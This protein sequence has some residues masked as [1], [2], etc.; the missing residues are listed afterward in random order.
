[1]HQRR[2]RG[3]RKQKIG[4][5]VLLIAAV[6]GI[7]LAG[8]TAARY[9][10]SLDSGSAVVQPDSFYFSSDLLAEDGPQYTIDPQLE[11]F[12]IKLFNGADDKRVNAADISYTVTVTNGSADPAGGTIKGGTQD[13]ATLTI[14]PDTSKAE[15]TVTVT[16]SSPYSKTLTGT[17]VRKTD[18]LY[19]VE[20]GEGDRAAVLNITV[21]DAAQT[22]TVTLPAG[23]IPDATDDRVTKKTE[24]SY[25]FTPAGAGAY[26]LVLLKTDPGTQLTEKQVTVNFS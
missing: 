20:D 24:N 23:V 26:S 14:T 15:V 1:M 16:S 4:L 25:Q 11:S 19:T 18:A 17:F 12:E 21:T 9:V 7:S 3:R 8:V 2:T 10:L 13:S 5:F 22:V 6:C